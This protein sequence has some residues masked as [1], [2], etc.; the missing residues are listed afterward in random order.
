LKAEY[1]SAAKMCWSGGK[2]DLVTSK[3]CL[4]SKTD[5]ILT[6]DWETNCQAVL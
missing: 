4:Q 1:I 6:F 2:S 3:F 5:V